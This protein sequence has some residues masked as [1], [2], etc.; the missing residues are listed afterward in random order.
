MLILQK[1]NENINLFIKYGI[2]SSLLSLNHLF[3]LFLLK[4]AQKQS[5]NT[6]SWQEHRFDYVNCH[7][8]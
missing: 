6:I 5:L 8:R 3:S 7:Y 2:I 4:W 1:L